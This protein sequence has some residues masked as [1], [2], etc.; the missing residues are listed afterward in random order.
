MITLGSELGLI[1]NCGKLEKKMVALNGL[2]K[3]IH[4]QCGRVILEIKEKRG[5]GCEVELIYV[6]QQG[7]QSKN[8]ACLLGL[9][10]IYKSVTVKI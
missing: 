9:A 8:G 3:Y 10:C 2:G 4:I 6:N 5:L 1:T 7:H